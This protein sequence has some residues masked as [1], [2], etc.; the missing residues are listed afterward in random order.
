LKSGFHPYISNVLYTK[1]TYC[2]KIQGLL[3]LP[4]KEGKMGA[5]MVVKVSKA[6]RSK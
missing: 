2:C 1:P 6:R 3:E 5:R 4:K